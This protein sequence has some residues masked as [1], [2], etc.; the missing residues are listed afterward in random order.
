MKIHKYILN[1][2]FVNDKNLQSYDIL[3][4]EKNNQ[5][6]LRPDPVRVKTCFG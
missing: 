1:E 6:E 2:L 4:I 3:K 5:I